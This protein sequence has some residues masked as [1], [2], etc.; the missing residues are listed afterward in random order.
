MQIELLAD[1]QAAGL[2]FVAEQDEPTRPLTMEE[3]NIYAALRIKYKPAEQQAQA[4]A[5]RPDLAA[6]LD[7]TDEKIKD[8]P[9][10][11][12]LKDNLKDDLDK[13][14]ALIDTSENPE[15]VRLARITKRLYKLVARAVR[16]DKE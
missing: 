9:I 8:V 14:N 15:V 4:L 1:L 2:P 5:K 10:I 16:A 3:R 6:L 13:L 11:K 12:D 7:K